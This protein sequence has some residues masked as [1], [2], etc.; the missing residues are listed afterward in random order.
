MF[1]F[2]Q[3]WYQR[4]FTDP[5]AALL[6]VM[7]ILSFIVIYFMG[8][9]LAPFFAAVIIAYMLEGSVDTMV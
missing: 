8:G 9:M 4:Y 2:L 6:A 5:Q 1:E 3:S 7:L